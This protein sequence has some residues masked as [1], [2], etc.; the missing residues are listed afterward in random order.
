MED[1]NEEEEKKEEGEELILS[2]LTQWRGKEKCDEEREVWLYYVGVHN[3]ELLLS[4][5]L[6]NYNQVNTLWEEC[7]IDA[8]EFHHACCMELG[9]QIHVNTCIQRKFGEKLQ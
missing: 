6:K 4:V 3:I 9:R 5:I 7:W 8:T 1:K 2:C